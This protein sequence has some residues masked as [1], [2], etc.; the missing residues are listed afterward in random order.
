MISD[1]E[2]DMFRDGVIFYVADHEDL[3]NRYREFV[4]LAAERFLKIAHRKALSGQTGLMY[5]DLEAVRQK[6]M[7]DN[8][9][10]QVYH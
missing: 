6:I 4:D 7:T 9:P 10:A 2:W 5:P 1:A 8:K 3:W